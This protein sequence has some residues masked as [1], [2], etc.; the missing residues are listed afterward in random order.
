MISDEW[1]SDRCTVLVDG[2][3]RVSCVTPARRVDGR[4]VTTIEG[5]P[6]DDRRR[7]GDAF[8]AAGASQCGFC[9]PGIIMRL[10]ALREKSPDERAAALIAIAAPQFRDGLARAWAA[11]RA[12]M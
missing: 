11:L 2:Q 9:T 8:C 4:S 3:P 5:L 6:D 12:R 1:P 7:W 10:H